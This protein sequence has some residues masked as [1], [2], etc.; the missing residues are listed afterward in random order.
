MASGGILA[1]AD[2]GLVPKVDEELPTEEKPKAKTKAAPSNSRVGYYAKEAE[3]I[4]GPALK[5]YEKPDVYTQGL[6]KVY[7]RSQKEEAAPLSDYL[8]Q[9]RETRTAAGAD[10]SFMEEEKR[11]LLQRKREVDLDSEEQTNLRK[12]QAWAMFGSTPG[13]ILASGLKAM[14]AYIE[15][16]VEDKK[17]R[18]KMLNEI[19]KAI[20]D[21]RK[22]DY[23]EKAGDAD[24]AMAFRNEAAKRSI[25]VGMKMS[26]IRT[27]QKSDILKSRTDIAE[28]AV[29]SASGE[30]QA[31][32]AASGRASADKTAKAQQMYASMTNT[33]DKDNEVAIKNAQIQ[34]DQARSQ[35]AISGEIPDILKPVAASAQAVLDKQKAE[36]KRIAEAISNKYP[37]AREILM[38]IQMP[39]VPAETP[40]PKAAPGG[41]K[42]LGFEK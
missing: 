11:R 40:K 25:E 1:F 34:L 36:H 27:Q 26:T 21:V 20:F 15:Q 9:I 31:A 8:K 17:E 41:V 19:D 5:E 32:I 4:I 12:A 38:G 29:T 10:N 42:F 3:K 18:K 33:Y 14:S 23:Q 22:A 6:E 39:S 2:E 35:A 24:A 30:S 13:P 28:K 16:T 37:E 7:A